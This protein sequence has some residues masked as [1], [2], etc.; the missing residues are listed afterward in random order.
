[1]DDT[2]IPPGLHSGQHHAA[3]QHRALDEEVQLSKVAGP[4]HFGHCGFGLRAGGVEYQHIDGAETVS[5][6][7]DQPGHLV[8]IG[9]IGEKALSGAAIL[10]DT[11]ADGSD[12]LVAGPAIYRDGGTVTGQAP[13]DHRPQ[14]PRAARHQSDPPMRHCHLAIIPPRSDH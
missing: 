6:R 3:E 14:A 1:V 11:A 10:T 5:D 13:R 2:A 7:G 12:V 4:G 9:D 8:L